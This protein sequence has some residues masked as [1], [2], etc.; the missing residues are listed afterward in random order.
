MGAASC[1]CTSCAT[2]IP[3]DAAF[4]PICGAPTPTQSAEVIPDDFEQR[5]TA[6]LAGRYAIE[7]ELGRGGMAVVYLAHDLRHERHVAVKVL[8]PDLAASVGAQRFLREIKLAAKLSHQNIV[9]LYDSGDADGF[10]YYVMPYVDGESLRHKLSREPQLAIDEALRLAQEIAEAL[11][12]AHEQGIIHRD[13][14]PGNILLSRGHALIADF[15]IAKVMGKLGA[16]HLTSTGSSLGTPLYVSPEQASGDPGVSHRTDIYSLG[17][18]LYEMLAGEPPFTGPSVQAILAKHA[19]EPRPAVRILRDSVPV[20]VQ[21]AIQRAMAKSPADRFPDCQAFVAAA[22]AAVAPL[23]KGAGVSGPSVRRRRIARWSSLLIGVAIIVG[24]AMPAIRRATTRGRSLVYP[25][26]PTWTA[27][28]D[29]SGEHLPIVALADSTLVAHRYGGDSVF[30]YDGETWTGIPIPRS[31]EMR[32][33]VGVLSGRRLLATKDSLTATGERLV[34]YWWLQL[35]TDALVPLRPLGPFEQGAVRSSWWSDGRAVVLWHGQSMR[36]QTQAGLVEESTGVAGQIRAMWGRD[37]SHRFALTAAALGSLLVYDGVGWRLT[38]VI[39]EEPA[40]TASFGGGATLA[41]G[42]TIVHGELCD[43]EGLCSPLLLRQDGFGAAWHRI[44]IPRRVGLPASQP[45]E[46]E[47]CEGDRFGFTGAGGSGGEDFYVWG[48][49]IRCGTGASRRF[50]AGCPLGQP[51]LWHVVDGVLDPVDDLTGRIVLSILSTEYAQYAIVDDGSLFRR[52][53]GGWRFVGQMPDLPYRLVAATRRLVLRWTAGRITFEPA[54]PDASLGFFV[55]PIGGFAETA[56]EGSRPHRLIARDSVL[57]ALT[58]DG[59]AFRAVC[60]RRRTPLSHDN[61]MLQCPSWEPL[62]TGPGPVLDIAILADQRVIGVGS[63]G[64]VVIWGDGSVRVEQV[65][66][67]LRTD[68]LW[69]LHV[70]SSGRVAAIG[71]T[72]VM[73]RDSLGAWHVVRRF[74]GDGA[75]GERFLVLP[76]GDIVVAGF[77]MHVWNRSTDSAP[78]AVLHRPVFGGSRVG[79]LHLLDDGRMVAGYANPERQGAGGWLQIWAAPVRANRWQRIALP[80]S[81]DVTG[82]ADDGTHLHVVGRG[83]SIAIPID[84][85][86]FSAERDSVP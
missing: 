4:C 56:A 54:G 36:R 55:A 77:W 19:L 81:I 15:G 60:A 33:Y 66:A 22:A 64:L 38:G 63:R 69:G 73:E 21:T 72:G 32:P 46:S 17:C 78:V 2:P 74:G 68:S 50:V 57:A 37:L 28:T 59:R 13:I 31:F 49:W 52:A 20:G 29:R 70:S 10:L 35:A 43:S 24:L 65:P 14:K 26:A 83:G 41:D 84:S 25:D 5:L 58:A 11:D 86:P 62:R 45:H 44:T 48:D 7:R 51:C 39:P 9:A 18:V 6:A 82:L 34:Q 53:S 8:R 1:I 71:R 30:T 75:S 40:G 42:T 79:A 47:A 85:L 12:Y 61:P 27:W 3:D 23:P 67:P 16:P 76:D 80:L